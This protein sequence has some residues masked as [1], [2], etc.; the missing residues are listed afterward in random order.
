MMR[1][2]DAAALL[3]ALAE[4]G[5]D[6]RLDG[7]WGVDALLGEQTRAH[8]DLDLF[9]ERFDED[10][11][12]ALLRECGYVPVERTFTTEAHTAWADG[13]GRE[14]D[15]HVFERAADGSLLFEGEAY[16]ASVFDGEGRIAGRAVRCIPPAEQV[17]FHCGYDHDEDDVHDVRLLCEHFGIPVPAEYAREIAG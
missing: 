2:E 16:P 15:L 11:T 12:V 10:A 6:V 13:E 1:E 17:A 7:G 4:R 9:V 5:V 14:V 3:E 8:N